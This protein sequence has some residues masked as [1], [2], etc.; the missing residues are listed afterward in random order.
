MIKAVRIIYVLFWMLVIFVLLTM[1]IPAS[2][3]KGIPEIDKI[4]HIVLFGILSYLIIYSLAG[5]K[6]EKLIFIFLFSFLIS[7]SYAAYMEYLQSFIPTRSASGLDLLAGIFG[8]L[9]SQIIFYSAY[10][11]KKT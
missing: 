2:Q 8:I 5:K 9:I 3:E 11:R 6:I 10:A 1:Q 7:G 4:V